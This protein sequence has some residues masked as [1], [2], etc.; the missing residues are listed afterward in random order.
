MAV[1]A[2]GTVVITGLPE[3]Q[4]QVTTASRPTVSEKVAPAPVQK[5]ASRAD[6]EHVVRVLNL[7]SAVGALGACQ[8]AEV[9]PK[10]IDIPAI[11]ATLAP[12]TAKWKERGDNIANAADY[13]PQL[14]NHSLQGNIVTHVLKDDGVT[15]N[16]TFVVITGPNECK[17]ARTLV[18]QELG[19][20]GVIR[21]VT[22]PG[23]SVQLDHKQ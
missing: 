4:T 10:D 2:L 18:L 7:V 21:G 14:F 15:V 11:I 5:K 6:I 23:K 3:K 12:M 20:S 22:A 9:E 8:I 13:A 16:R 17:Q 19:P 1:L